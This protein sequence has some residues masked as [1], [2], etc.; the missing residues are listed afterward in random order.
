MNS[1]EQSTTS[2]AA[3]PPPTPAPS[4]DQQEISNN[5]AKKFLLETVSNDEKQQVSREKPARKGT[6][7]RQKSQE[8]DEATAFLEHN[9]LESKIPNNEL[10]LE[11]MLKLDRSEQNE[12]NHKEL[13]IE[14]EELEFNENY[15]FFNSTTSEISNYK[16]KIVSRLVSFFIIINFYLLISIF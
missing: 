11:R 6:T 7:K 12:D 10:K 8:I 2:L 3:Q 1:I 15:K 14:L 13:Y 9:K 5:L 4:I 16:W